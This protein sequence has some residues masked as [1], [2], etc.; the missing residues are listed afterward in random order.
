MISATFN[1]LITFELDDIYLNNSINTFI[2]CGLKGWGSTTSTGCPDP[3][4]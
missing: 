2:D 4:E 1:N 3:C